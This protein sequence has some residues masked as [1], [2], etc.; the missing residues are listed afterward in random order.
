[1]F[2]DDPE[3][4][5]QYIYDQSTLF[6]L[7]SKIKIISEGGL[8]TRGFL[9]N[10]LPDKPL[11]SVVTVVYNG[12]QYLQST[13]ESILQQSYEN[14]ELVVVDGGSTD[15]TLDIIQKYSDY[16]DYWV[17][18][19]D[20][21]IYDAMNR[22]IDLASGDWINFMNVGDV[23]YSKTTLEE[24]FKLDLQKIDAVF[25]DTQMIDSFGE[26]YKRE[27]SKERLSFVHQ[28]IIYRKSLHFKFGKYLVSK[29]VTISDY[30]FFSNVLNSDVGVFK[31]NNIISKCL[32]GGISDDP[33]TLYQTQAFKFMSKKMSK[34]HFLFFLMA[35]PLYRF[36]KRFF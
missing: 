12:D 19:K 32:L 5:L 13:I 17:S 28:S 21:G 31:T 22:G 11:I 35:Y 25:S 23:F 34:S 18:A 8:R 16:I 1:M 6:K 29:G 33:F 2:K 36:V 14:V 24:V 26:E 7:S 30:I 9:K 15:D 10:K 20:Q 27:F 3:L 4:R